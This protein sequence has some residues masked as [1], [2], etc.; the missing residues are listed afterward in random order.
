MFSL[1]RLWLLFWKNYKLR[2]RHP[3]ILLFEIAVPCLFTIILVV[4]RSITTFDRITNT[5]TFQQREIQGLSVIYE[6][7]NKLV[8]FGPRTNKTIEL[9]NI[10]STLTQGIK[11]KDFET[12]D[13]MVD[14]YVQ[15]DSDS[16]RCGV[17]FNTL[18]NDSLDFK[19]RFSFAPKALSNDFEFTQVN[20]F[21][22]LTARNFP[23][24]QKPGPR[25]PSSDEGGPPGYLS[26]GFLFIQHYISRAYAYQQKPIETRKFFNHVHSYNVLRFPYPPYN[27]DQ[28]MFSL[29]FM[30]PMIMMIISV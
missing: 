11:V 19:L 29:Q 22:W 13:E 9:M 27:N 21:T 17:W 15:K 8:L 10:F 1:N 18:T 20:Q 6:F 30:F 5:T 2:I 25:T 16:I 23:M 3:W 24:F 14:Y 28:F 7:Q 26:N 12:E 4:V